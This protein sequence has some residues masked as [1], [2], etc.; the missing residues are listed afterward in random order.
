MRITRPCW[1]LLGMLLWLMR[2]D[3]Y[4]GPRQPAPPGADPYPTGRPGRAD[5]QTRRATTGAP[6]RVMR[7]DRPVYP[8]PR[9]A[10]V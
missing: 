6:P 7:D 2:C 8:R 4:V 10:S 5:V 1:L 9:L 3:T